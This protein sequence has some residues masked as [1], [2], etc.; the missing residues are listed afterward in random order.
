MR[1]QPKRLVQNTANRFG[2]RIARNIDPFR[3]QYTLLSGRDV[4]TILDAGAKIGDC[5]AS[6]RS[7][8]PGAMVHA[9]EPHPGCVGTL[10]DRF[11]SDDKVRIEPVTL[12]DRTGTAIMRVSRRQSTH[13]FSSLRG[14]WPPT[15]TRSSICVICTEARTASCAGGTRS[16][17][18]RGCAPGSTRGSNPSSAATTSRA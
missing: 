1:E 5:T 8:F 9:F 15:A 10:S 11:G 2:Y 17:S 7:L 6:Y 13:C 3:Q 14:S 18:A 16:L 4:R 12:G